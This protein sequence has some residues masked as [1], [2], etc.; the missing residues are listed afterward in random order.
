MTNI[1]SN[2]GIFMVIIDFVCK[3]IIFLLYFLYN[4][5]FASHIPKGIGVVQDNFDYDFDIFDLVQGNFNYDLYQLSHSQQSYL[6]AYIFYI[7]LLG[8]I[9]IFIKSIS[10]LL[11]IG[12]IHLS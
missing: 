2:C 9:G 10:L 1:C 6:S 8:D 12:T 7:S 5:L 11:L 4:I 3:I